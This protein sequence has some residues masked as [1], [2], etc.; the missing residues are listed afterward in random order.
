MF[1]QLHLDR[2]WSNTSE[3][4]HEMAFENLVFVLRNYLKHGY[5]NLIV[6]DLQDWRIGS[7]SDAFAD[8]DFRIVACSEGSIVEAATE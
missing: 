8:R 1:R 2:E 5:R 3:E 6:D 7:L 4:E